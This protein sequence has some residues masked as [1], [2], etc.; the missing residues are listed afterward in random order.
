M[1][2]KLMRVLMLTTALILVGGSHISTVFAVDEKPATSASKNQES[3]EKL[4]QA[5]SDIEEQR[6][7][8]QDLQ[9][10]LAKTTGL[11]Q[12]AIE[13]RLDKAWLNL[14]EQGLAFAKSVADQKKA[15]VEVG[16]YQQHAIDVFSNS[17]LPAQQLNVFSHAS[18]SQS[19]IYP[20]RNRRQPTHAS[21]IP[22]PPLTRPMKQPSRACNWRNNLR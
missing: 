19:L 8:I 6:Q 17:M 20:R 15:E 11:T 2:N 4:Q 12:K 1:K 16:K 7:T 22:W 10:R 3:L 5:Y 13:V 14:L 21:S 9:A 18:K